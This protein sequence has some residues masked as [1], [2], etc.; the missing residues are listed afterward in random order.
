RLLGPLGLCV[1]VAGAGALAGPMAWLERR[2][3]RRGP[4]LALGLAAAGGA[5]TLFKPPG[6][7]GVGVK[8]EPRPTAD[9]RT[10]F[11]DELADMSGVGT[12]SNREFLPREVFVPTYTPGNPRGRNVYERLY[13][14]TEWIGGLFYPLAGDVRVL[15]WRAAPL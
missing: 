13:P 6:D 10:V 11:R 5:G 8:P 15:G 3:P 9:G 4:G 14:E 12:T 2:W 1:A 7:R